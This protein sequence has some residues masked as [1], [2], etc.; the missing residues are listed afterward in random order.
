MEDGPRAVPEPD[1]EDGVTNNRSRWRVPIHPA[2]SPASAAFVSQF[3][4][5]KFGAE[6]AFISD[7]SGIIT[8]R[9]ETMLHESP[10]SRP[11]SS[12]VDSVQVPAVGRWPP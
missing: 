7:S 9:E 6:G 12:S 11:K 4:I 5:R 2:K 3:V 10:L 8:L 1:R